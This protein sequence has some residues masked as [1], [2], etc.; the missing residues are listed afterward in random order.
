MHMHTIGSAAKA[1]KNRCRTELSAPRLPVHGRFGGRIAASRI[2]SPHVA[3]SVYQHPPLLLLLLLLLFLLLFP[4]RTLTLLLTPF[5][6]FD[7]S[8]PQPYH[9][10]T[11]CHTI[12][13]LAP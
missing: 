4:T 10:I 1:R 2:N 12:P 3:P 6:P 11:R 8:V 7:P 5:S 9:P 13:R